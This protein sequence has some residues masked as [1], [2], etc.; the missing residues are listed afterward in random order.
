MDDEE[1][2]ERRAEDGSDCSRS[3]SERLSGIS[4]EGDGDNR[5]DMAA[6][7]EEDTALLVPPFINKK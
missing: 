7:D 2:A 1:E 6:L 4:G 3:D 5:N